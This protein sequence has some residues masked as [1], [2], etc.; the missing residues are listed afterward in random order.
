MM[1][2]SKLL[3][4]VVGDLTEKYP[5]CTEVIV[6]SKVLPCIH[7]FCL[8]CLEQFWKNKQPGDSVPCPLYR[9][10]FNIPVGGLSGL[11]RNYF[12]EKLLEAKRCSHEESSNKTCDI[13]SR[14]TH[15]KNGDPSPATKYCVC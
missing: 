13:C 6:D 14:L 7:T 8:K 2:A 1:E 3:Y 4:E 12:V 15:E 10:E 11:P 9:T 5:I